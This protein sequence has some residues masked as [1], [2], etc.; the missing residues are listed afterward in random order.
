[1]L[2]NN[3]RIKKF[4]FLLI[5]FTVL[6]ISCNKAVVNYGE[7]ALTEDPNIISVDTMTV[8]L[9]TFQIDSF[10]T[11]ADTIFK[12]GIHEDTLLGRYETKAFL[13]LGVPSSNALNQCTNCTF[14]SIV[15]VAR[16]SAA[17]YGDTTEN[18]NLNIHRLTQQMLPDV[19]SIGYNVSSFQYESTPLGTLQLTNT[20]PS[21]EKQFTVRLDDNLGTELYGMLKRNSDTITNIDKFSK[22]FN[23]LA[24]TGN[25]T[26][27]QS[28]YYFQ[29]YDTASAVV[30]K[31]Y[32]SVSGTS[33]TQNS[34]N[35]PISPSSYQF[36]NYS[37]DK[38]GTNLTGFI[39]KKTMVL[40]STQTGNQAYLHDNSGL[41]PILNIPAIFSIKDLHP[42]VQVIKAELTI[43]PSLINYG[44]T[45]H[46]SLPPTIGLRSFDTVN[47]TF[48]SF[49]TEI[50]DNSA[51]QDGNL[52]I[53]NIN[54]VNTKYT[55]DLTTY[56]NNIL[57]NG[58]FTQQPLALIPLNS[59]I[60]NRLIINN[61]LI[62]K[63]VK[64]KLY[65]LGL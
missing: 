23:G 25:G 18:F 19:T 30:M 52:V 10:S 41:Y 48:G 20:R 28:I 43:E 47:Y 7:E 55:F 65:V 29:Q 11:S 9:S 27:N 38:T 56:V 35:F 63:S 8:D 40:P 46:Y 44:P 4:V 39:S 42:Y 37:Y 16:Y 36:N 21:Q 64:L 59:S 51:N 45:N 34:I 5:G 54:H 14:D 15:F 57:K 33:T 12:V 2:H 17:T 49:L 62:D 1:M 26:N 3:Q 50:T 53:D 60:E 13:Q 22:Y 6:A 24:I 61:N 32:Y 31:V 58:R